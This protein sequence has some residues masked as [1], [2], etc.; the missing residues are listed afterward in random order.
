MNGGLHLEV[1]LSSGVVWAARMHSARPLSLCQAMVGRPAAH[2][3][4]AVERI[5]ALCGRSHRVAAQLALD[6]ARGHELTATA[7][8]EAV[9]DLAAE[10]A[11]EHLRS[12]F[13]AA[14]SLGVTA[15]AVEMDAI[16]TAVMTTRPGATGTGLASALAM[17]GLDGARP[18]RTSWAGRVLD[19]VGPEAD[20]AGPVDALSPDD[21]PAVL[22]RLTAHGLPYAA[23]P[24]LPLRRPETGPLARCFGTAAP[25]DRMAARLAEIV[26]AATLLQTGAELASAAWVACATLPDG[27]GFAAVESP[28]GRM[29]YLVALDAHSRVTGCVVLAP[30]EWNFHPDGPLVHALLGLRVGRGAAA[31]RRIRWLIAL[32]DPCV[33]C[34]LDLTER[35]NA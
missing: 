20:G 34:T 26:Q 13:T 12:T 6:A 3:P 33:A 2:V 25:R 1:A 28:R 8:R 22:A 15:T 18:A 14:S 31:E 10:R 17:L 30:T 29:H 7:R 35:V 16:R 32:F 21:D 27:S 19:A 4:A 23:L 24:H 5:Y 11:G 9:R